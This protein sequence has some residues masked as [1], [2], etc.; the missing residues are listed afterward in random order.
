MWIIRSR[1]NERSKLHKAQDQLTK[2]VLISSGLLFLTLLYVWLIQVTP[3]IVVPKRYYLGSLVI[4][5]SS[6]GLVGTKYAIVR[7]KLQLAV[8]LL[9]I[10]TGMGVAFGFIQLYG[11]PS[12]QSSN[13][14]GNNIFL[15]FAAIH[16][17]HLA[18]GITFLMVVLRRLNNFQVHSKS[19]RF[20]SNVFLFWHFLGL[21]WVAFMF[22]VA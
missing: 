6:L 1:L 7:D 18:V 4:V 19:M 15:P 14:I 16:F 12:L 2:L 3:K 20:T 9:V 8:Y 5:L 17:L 21:I 22:L 10:S 13:Q 11:W